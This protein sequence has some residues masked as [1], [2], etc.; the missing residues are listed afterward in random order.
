MAVSALIKGAHT[1]SNALATSAIA[2]SSLLTFNTSG[3]TSPNPPATDLLSAAVSPT[4]ARIDN[5]P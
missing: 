5:S 2:K 3:P 1:S 4:P